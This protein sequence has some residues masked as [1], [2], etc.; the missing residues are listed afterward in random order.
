MSMIRVEGLVKAYGPTLAVDGVSF[1]V[2]PGELV[3]FLGKN[4]AGKTTTMRVLAGALG[5]TDGLVQIGGLDVEKQPDQVKSMIGYLPE[6]PPL[7]LDMTVRSFLL[8]AARL[9]GVSDARSAVDRVLDEVS[10]RPVA[11]RLIQNLSKGY[12][13]RVGIA[14][15]ILHRPKVLILDEPMSG[16][17]PAQ[18]REIRDL[19]VNLSRGETTVLLSTHVL[20]EIENVVD[21]VIVLDRGRVVAQDTVAAL[22]SSG[23]R[24]VVVVARP[25]P[26][27]VPQLAALSG[28]SQ[29]LDEGNGRLTVEADSDV[30][31]AVATVAVA[32][33]LLEL[34][35]RDNLEDT[36]LRLTG[37]AP[38]SE[39]SS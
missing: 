34:R 10:L 20:A 1:S 3:G 2:E 9:R 35:S 12:R 6:V 17:D 38:E 31:E 32:F 28:V 13:Q 25:T 23:R 8:F 29:V 15:A 27:V 14:Q 19:V 37:P 18:R 22:A 33:G 5:A 21:R 7:Y 4:G 26:E 24:F 39:V 36:F 11:G 30:R 16:L